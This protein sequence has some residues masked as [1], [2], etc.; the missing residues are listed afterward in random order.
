MHQLVEQSRR[1]VPADPGAA[2]DRGSSLRVL[3]ITSRFTTFLQYSMRDWLASF[4]AMGHQTQLLIEQADHEMAGP[5]HFAQVCAEFRPDLL[6]LIDHYRGEFHGLPMNVPCVMWVQDRLPNIFRAQA[7]AAQGDLDYVLGYGRQE[8]VVA[9]GYPRERFLP[10]MVGFNAERFNVVASSGSEDRTEA[11]DVSFVSHASMPPEKLVQAEI[12]KTAVPEVKRFLRDSLDRLR[13]IYDDGGFVTE[14]GHI[15]KIVQQ[16]MQDHGVRTSD[17]SA[18]MDFFVQK[19]NNA[20]FRQQAIGWVAEL[21]VRLHL[22]GRGWEQHPTF[23]AFAR[24]VADNERQLC[25]IYRSSAINLQVTPFGAVHQRLFDGLAAGG[26]FLL[27][28]CT[29]DECDRIYQTMWRW[30]EQAQIRSGQEFFHCAPDHIRGLIQR[31]IELTGVN[32]VPIAEAFFLGLEEAAGAGFTRS[33]ATLWPQYDRVAFGTREEL[34]RHIRHFLAN[35]AERA[36]I[37]HSMRARIAD[38]MSYQAISAR[39]LRF[40]AEDMRSRRGRLSLAA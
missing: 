30:C 9:H 34:H 22:Y 1:H 35:P 25:G 16:S 23:A 8:C 27:R 7:G 32:P 36:G 3:G 2:V 33:P 12:D 17:E 21:G 19:V 4:Q 11:C 20:L 26:F 39:L 29:G 14:V 24:G 31:V 10:S 18:V 28:A 13:A 5:M 40:I 38:Q 37:A 15:R 6:L